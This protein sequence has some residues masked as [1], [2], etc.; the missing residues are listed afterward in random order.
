MIV[1]DVAIVVVFYSMLKPTQTG[2]NVK[3]WILMRR[4]VVLMMN[5]MGVVTAVVA[6]PIFSALVH[7]VITGSSVRY[8]SLC[9]PPQHV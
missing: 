5:A 6:M 7:Q 1:V 2:V 9:A 3:S 4:V 8:Q